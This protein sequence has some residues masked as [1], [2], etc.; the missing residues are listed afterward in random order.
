MLRDLLKEAKL[1]L[2]KKKEWLQGYNNCHYL[3]FL[4]VSLM[5]PFLLFFSSYT[6]ERWEKGDA[7]EQ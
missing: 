5:N 7:K 6:A 1:P 2:I 3:Q 4:R